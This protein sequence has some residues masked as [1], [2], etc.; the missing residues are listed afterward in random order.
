MIISLLYCLLLFYILMTLKKIVFMIENVINRYFFY[1]GSGNSRCLN[2]SFAQMK[3]HLVYRLLLYIYIC[4]YLYIFVY[5]CGYCSTYHLGL[6]SLSNQTLKPLNSHEDSSGMTI[7][8]FI[9][10]MQLQRKSYM[11]IS[12]IFMIVNSELHTL[13][14]ML[15]YCV[16]KNSL[17]WMF[18]LNF[19]PV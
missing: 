7:Y 1:I 18:G 4:I 16:I 19:S 2:H 11:L 9:F 6:L 13:R 10:V 17:L 8:C 14:K 15:H 12:F 3:F 5:I